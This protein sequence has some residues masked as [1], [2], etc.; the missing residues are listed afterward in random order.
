MYIYIYIIY[1][2]YTILY[3]IILYD[4]FLLRKHL[5]HCIQV[6]AIS[7]SKTALR[8]MMQPSLGAELPRLAAG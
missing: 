3:Y 6:A 5:I 2:Y 1:M 4:I 8:Q 7:A